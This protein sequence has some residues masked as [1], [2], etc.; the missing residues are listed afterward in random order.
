MVSIA[1]RQYGILVYDKD[2]QHT[3]TNRL[4][5]QTVQKDIHLQTRLSLKSNKV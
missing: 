3:K 4:A 1:Y 5:M 2:A